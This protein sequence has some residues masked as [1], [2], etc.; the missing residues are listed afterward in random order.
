[1]SLVKLTLVFLM[2]C[3]T[4]SATAFDFDPKGSLGEGKFKR[5]VPP[6]AQPYFNE[7]PYITTEARLVYLYNEIRRSPIVS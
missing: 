2:V 4:S 6:L 3:F 7:T 5:Y 1:M